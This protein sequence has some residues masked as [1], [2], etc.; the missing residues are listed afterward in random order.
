M[1][2]M[3][4]PSVVESI[5]PA[6]VTCGSGVVLWRSGSQSCSARRVSLTRHGGPV[7]AR[8][9]LPRD[10]DKEAHAT[11]ASLV[12]LVEVT[13]VVSATSG[14]GVISEGSHKHVSGV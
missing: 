10:R 2:V 13:N 4:P 3:V 7:H 9:R 6:S 14:L 11:A 8:L 5:K 12:S 1:A